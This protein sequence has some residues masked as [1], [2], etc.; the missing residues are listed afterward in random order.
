M[1]KKRADSK[2]VKPKRLTLGEI[3]RA[4][5]E[6]DNSEKEFSFYNSC[7]SKR[8]IKKLT[9]KGIG[10]VRIRPAKDTEGRPMVFIRRI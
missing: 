4:M 8:L 7:I 3:E 9:K 5:N 10:V 6:A 2:S 1:L